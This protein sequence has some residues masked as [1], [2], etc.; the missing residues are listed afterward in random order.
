MPIWKQHLLAR[1]QAPAG[2]DGSDTGGSGGGGGDDTVQGG[3]GDDTIQGGGGDD[4]L[5]GGAGGN[6]GAKQPTDAEAK[7]LKEVMQKKDALKKTTADLESANA[8]LKEFDGVDPAEI[9]KLI[10]DKKAAEEAQ[11]AAKGDFETLRKR[12]ADEHQ[13]AVKGLTDENTSLKQQNVTLHAQLEELTVGRSFND[14]QFIK[15]TVY[16]PSK[17]RQ[18]YASH[19]DIVDGAV[20]GFD[21]ARGAQGRTPLVDASGVNLPFDE[22]FKR[23]VDADPEKDHILKSKVKTGAGS[24]SQGN[25]PRR[26]NNDTPKTG[27]DKINAGLGSLKIAK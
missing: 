24:S 21:K 25:P 6:K 15:E 13:T 20:V 18:L 8:R 5:D 4:T 12:M 1:Y 2:E 17:A 26:S 23:L 16:T 22:A 11:L 3:S 7:L 14:S 19:F 27:L 9:K 10:A